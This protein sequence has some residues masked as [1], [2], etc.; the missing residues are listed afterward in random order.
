MLGFVNFAKEDCIYGRRLIKFTGEIVSGIIR[1]F[2]CSVKKRGDSAVN[3]EEGHQ[4][5]PRLFLIS[6]P[7]SDK[8]CT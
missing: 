3:R 4:R 6:I 1:F 2:E 8:S 5:K 7:G